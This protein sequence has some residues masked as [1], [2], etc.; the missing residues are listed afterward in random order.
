MAGSSAHERT[1]HWHIWLKHKDSI[2]PYLKDIRSV[3][4][5]LEFLELVAE[6]VHSYMFKVRLH[7][8]IYALKLYAVPE[9]GWRNFSSLAW[10]EDV[11]LCSDPFIVEYRVYDAL[12]EWDLLGKVGPHC[13]GW[14]TISNEQ[15]QD[16]DK[17][18]NLRH[19]YT[20]IDSAL[21]AKLKGMGRRH[22]LG[23]RQAPQKQQDPVRGLLLE[24]IDGTSLDKAFVDEAGA[25]CLRT[26]LRDLHSLDIV[27]ADFYPRNVMVSRSGR[28]YIIDFSSARLWPCRGFGRE[29]EGFLDYMECEKGALEYYLFQLQGLQ[30]HQNV[31]LTEAKSDEEAYGGRVSSDVEV[32]KDQFQD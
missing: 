3:S 8:T 31:K 20:T 30:R 27:H 19:G 32:T 26:Q 28:P 23:F 18:F 16:L 1:S 29:K 17:R 12:I 7:G 15:E 2:C 22:W 25:A 14:L 4:P 5:D 11:V 21:I 13:S 9:A 6:S 24:W 10:V